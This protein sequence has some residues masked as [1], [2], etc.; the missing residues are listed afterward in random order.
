VRFVERF[1][2]L[3]RAAE[4]STNQHL[5]NSMTHRLRKIYE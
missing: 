2:A 1:T 3:R 4:A 5:E